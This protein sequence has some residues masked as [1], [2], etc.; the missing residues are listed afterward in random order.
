MKKLMAV[1]LMFPLFAF[2]TAC[3]TVE[4]VGKDIKKVGSAL[5]K[6]ATKKKTQ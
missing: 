1:V 4:G 6:E 3:S 2:L 5:E